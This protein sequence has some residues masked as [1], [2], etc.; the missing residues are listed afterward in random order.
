[1]LAASTA[2]AA[3]LTDFELT[4]QNALAQ[5][6]N[7]T[8]A[9]A[10]AKCKGMVEEDS[11]ACWR[12]F[13]VEMANK[14][15]AAEGKVDKRNPEN[16]FTPLERKIFNEIRKTNPQF[17]KLYIDSLAT[18]KDPRN[19]NKDKAAAFVSQ[20]RDPLR[21]WMT[22]YASNASG[23][24]TQNE[25]VK[26]VD[27]MQQARN[28]I[29]KGESQFDNNSLAA[30]DNAVVVGAQN[31]RGGKKKKE[32]VA[33]T[34]RDD[35]NAKVSDLKTGVPPPGELELKPEAPVDKNKWNDEIAGGK[36]AVWAGMIALI[37]GGPVGAVVFAAIGYGVFSGIHKMN[38]A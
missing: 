3:G 28:A 23:F 27:A 13:L 2:G 17:D 35:K 20:F 10:V 9:A 37:L 12:P 15:T 21:G 6:D 30:S 11:A 36:G 5:T 4:L 33:T 1:M 16:S 34:E 25:T 22:S 8:Y 38:N 14:Y 29:L 19:K 32:E 18:A 31:N 24:N 26:A 7:A